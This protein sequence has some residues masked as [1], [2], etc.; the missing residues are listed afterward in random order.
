MMISGHSIP[1]T[2]SSLYVKSYVFWYADLKYIFKGLILAL[3]THNVAVKIKL[4]LRH[5]LEV[6]YK[7]FYLISGSEI[8]ILDYNHYF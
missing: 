8:N 4:Y 2:I 1:Q 7:L 5:G 6:F 3:P